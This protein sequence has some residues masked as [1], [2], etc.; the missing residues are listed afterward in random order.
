[1]VVTVGVVNLV[2]L[3]A[4]F[5]CVATLWL[6]PMDA[7]LY[8]A[9]AGATIHAVPQVI[10]AGQ[11]H[12]PDAAAMA[13]LVKLTRVTL[14]APSV[15]LT[16][17][18]VS[19]RYQNSGGEKQARQ[20]LWRYVPWFVWGFIAVA[21]VRATGWLPTLE[22]APGGGGAVRLPLGEALPFVAKWLLAVSMA[23]IGLQVHLRPMLRA[24]AKAM[25]AGVIGWLVMAAAA[26]LLLRLVL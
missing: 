16:A 17:L 12:G 20:P 18:F 2:G 7:A 5:A 1:M 4:M 6:F 24:G 23:A 11:S 14:L 15:V 13:T 10:A 26:V 3:L 19:R 21:I 9:W 22:F 25:A 8:G